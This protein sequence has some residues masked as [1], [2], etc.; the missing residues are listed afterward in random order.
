MGVVGK[1]R[2]CFTLDIEWDYGGRPGECLK[3]LD[4]GKEE[5]EKLQHFVRSEGIPLSLFVQTSLLEKRPDLAEILP[6]LGSE[7]N[8]H[9]HTHAMTNFKS[10]DELALSLESIK[11]TFGQEKIGYRAPGGKLYPGD[12]ERIKKLGY[13][14]DS[15]IFPSFRPGWFNNLHLPIEPYMHTNGL[16]ELPFAVV[17]RIRMMLG[18]SYMRLLGF[19]AVQQLMR[20]FGLPEVVVFYGHLHDF[21]PTE[22]L[23]NLPFPIKHALG[24]NANNGLEITQK[25]A[26][27]LRQND[28]E[29]IT[30]NELADEVMGKL[31]VSS[32]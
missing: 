31:G 18:L 23:A 11:T 21:V 22:D 1:K 8:S 20:I 16:L 17:P 4:T 26:A 6:Q 29:F 9:S 28:Y 24:R 19:S 32:S 15:S 27:Y 2:A 10:D 5:I 14:F 25:V 13:H 30:M 3:T 7:F 12:L